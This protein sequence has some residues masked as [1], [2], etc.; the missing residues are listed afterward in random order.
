MADEEGGKA[1]SPKAQSPTQAP[2]EEESQQQEFESTDQPDTQ[3]EA[4]VKPPETELEQNQEEEQSESDA[5]APSPTEE[6]E[7]KADDAGRQSKTP[8][9][10]DA[11]RQAKSPL[12]K[13][14]SDVEDTHQNDD[15]EVNESQD[16]T[17]KGSIVQPHCIDLFTNF[18]NLEIFRSQRHILSV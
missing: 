4:N 15:V 13:E 17:E 6:T 12:Q 1:D 8:P 14:P 7:K 10:D 16:K 11:G 3:V 18:V 5:K 9:P 2:K